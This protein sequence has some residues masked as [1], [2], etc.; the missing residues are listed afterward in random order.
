MQL[1]Y[2]PT[3]KAID[4][5]PML[6][7]VEHYE[8]ICFVYTVLHVLPAWYLFV[9]SVA[10]LCTGRSMASDM[11]AHGLC[12]ISPDTAPPSVTGGC[13]EDLLGNAPCLFLLNNALKHRSSKSCV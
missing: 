11:R 4:V 5:L 2:R 12:C 10:L 9:C 8:K 7:L 13:A 6:T 3:L 1:H